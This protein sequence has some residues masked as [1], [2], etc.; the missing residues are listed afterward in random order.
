M[1]SSAVLA[2]SDDFRS[3]VL[4]S[5]VP[6]IVDF[7]ARW[8]GPCRALAPLLDE[9]AARHAGR[10]RVTVV[11]VEQSPE[12]SQAYRVTSM[13]T[14]IAFRDGRPVAQLV[15][16]TGRRSVERLFDELLQGAATGRTPISAQSSATE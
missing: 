5:E 10:V 8:C 9:L 4:E 14:L 2:T 1:N 11:D 12:L 3:Q 15:G 13:P 7:T 6:V 16:Y